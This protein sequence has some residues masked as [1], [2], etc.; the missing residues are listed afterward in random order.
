M[1]QLVLDVGIGMY[2]GRAYGDENIC[3]RGLH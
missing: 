1:Q 2:A 3:W